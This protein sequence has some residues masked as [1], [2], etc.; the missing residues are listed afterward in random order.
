MEIGP[1]LEREYALRCEVLTDLGPVIE[2][3]LQELLRAKGLR[4]HSVRHRIKGMPNLQRK[5][6]SNDAGYEDLQEVH[7]L[8][9]LRV[10]T[11][12]PDEVDAVAEV[13]EGEFEHDLGYQSRAAI[14]NE[15]RRRFSR[16][17]GVL[18]MA[19]D[20]FQSLRNDVTEYQATVE[21]KVDRDPDS[22]TIDQDSIHA[23]LAGNDRIRNLDER[24]AE[25]LGREL[26][27][28]PG[29]TA[30]SIAT[31]LQ[32][33]GLERIAEVEPLIEEREEMIV[34]FARQWIR[35]EKTRPSA[36]LFAGISLF[37]LAYVLVTDELSVER[38]LGYFTGTG[39]GST[40]DQQTLAQELVAVRRA[41]S[42]EN[43]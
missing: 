18:E 37:Y 24:V 34:E 6:S 14:P 11:F 23:L 4:V 17:A 36:Q 16:L 1:E 32:F 10:I 39:I 13:V 27:G 8:L 43:G 19:D 9:G 30:G 38:A 22:V 15:M 26:I 20:E 2:R 21:G 5:L 35:R 29:M 31:E 3:L 7:D 12:F 41:I 42:E 28:D 33:A 25:A 40:E